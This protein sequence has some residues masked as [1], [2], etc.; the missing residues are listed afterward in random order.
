M[1][2]PTGHLAGV[3][4]TCGMPGGIS[5]C[6]KNMIEDSDYFLAIVVSSPHKIVHLLLLNQ[7]VAN[8]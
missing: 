3:G 8:S 6:W 7:L 4:N 5:G 1:E 2:L